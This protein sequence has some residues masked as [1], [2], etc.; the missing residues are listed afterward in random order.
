MNLN[1]LPGATWLVG[2]G[3]MAGAMVQGWRLAGVD[4]TQATVI[5]PSGREV[6][7]VRT[8]RTPFEAGRPPELVILGFKPQQLDA[9]AAD[10]APRLT[11]RT[12]VISILA[13]VE[14]ASLR[15]RFPGAAAVIRAMP[16]LPVV[17]RRGVVALHSDDADEA[18][19]ERLAQLF[20]VLG[21]AHW[22]ASEQELA[23]VGS[24]AGAGPAYVAR[25]IAALTKAG[26]AR[27]L[28][29]QIAETV[30]RETVLGTAWL[31]A[32]SGESMD[33]I[34]RRVASP[35]GTT[36]A[37]LAVLDREAVLDQLVAVTIE[38]AARRGAELADEARREPKL[39]DPTP[40]A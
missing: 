17:V 31:A 38:A 36:E 2:C 21:F 5:R 22:T 39:A 28:G 16:N 18:L 37:G 20:S 34:A 11:S 14:T 6:E 10:L 24:V 8:V 23:A 19:R 7:G 32:T 33:D 26:I 12:V 35:K 40:L 29:E 30:A 3:N 13:G 1:L 25:F 27:G 9:V 4:L 15:A